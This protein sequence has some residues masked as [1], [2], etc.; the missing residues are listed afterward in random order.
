MVT[1]ELV[2][3]STEQNNNILQKDKERRF[4][5]NAGIPCAVAENE[6]KIYFTYDISDK[7]VKQSILLEE[8]FEL[9]KSKVPRDYIELLSIRPTEKDKQRTLLQ[10]HLVDYTA[11]NTFDY[12]IHKD[13][14]GFLSRELDFF[15]KNEVLY[16]DDINTRNEQEF[17]K[18]LSKIKAVKKIGDKIITFLSQIENF[19]KKLWLKKK[20]I[21]EC[22]YCITLDR[23]P[24]E[25]YQEI[26]KNKEQIN[27]W[28]RLFAIDEIKKDE[29]EG[30]FTDGF[31][32]YSNPPSI[33]SLK[34]N[35]YLV[36]DTVFFKEDF[37]WKL[38]TSIEN[39]D[40]KCDGLLINSENFQ[41]LNLL[42]NRFLEITDCI[43][44]DPPYNA[45]SS[46]ILYKNNFKHASWISLLENRISLSRKLLKDKF[47]HITAIDEVENFNIGKLFENIFFECENA[48]VS[49]VHN[50]TGQQGRNFSYTHEFAHFIYPT[51]GN[52]IGLENRD[53]KT[54]EAEPD[55]RPLRN[56]SSG[57]DHLRESAANCFYPIYIKD[58]KIIGFGEVCPV[59]FHPGKINIKRYDDTIEIYPV[60][61]SNI[62]S[63]WVFARNTVESII[64]E[65]T[66]EYDKKKNTWD[67]IRRKSKFRYKSLWCDKRY[68]ANSWGSVILNNI[69][70]KNPFTYPKSIYTVMDC[71]DAGL[72]NRN[73]GFIL[74]YF[75]GSGTTGHAII[76]LNR[77]DSG[78]RKY[79]LVEMGEYFDTVT[80]P[81]ILKVVYSK[82]WKDG[83]PISREGISHCI[84]YLRLES[85]EDTLNNLAL[86]QT[87]NQ[88]QALE[89]NHQFKEGYMLNYML[90]VETN[91]SLLNLEWFVNPFE[92]Y[93]NITKNNE[94]KPTK[95]DLVETFN[96]L[97]GLVVDNYSLPKD[98]YVIVTGKNLNDEK[99]LVVWRDCKKHNNIDLNRFLERSKYNPLDNEYNKIYV[100]GDNNVENLKIGDEQWK[101][102]L[103][104]EEFKKRMFEMN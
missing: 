89:I 99:I 47:V 88:Q 93:L 29:N 61:P 36:L 33:E 26:I 43:Y 69:L 101:V 27:E 46:E 14:Y 24:K 74:D 103:I 90:D 2:E 7:K 21:V 8:A 1:F 67:I 65:L 66:A 78:N 85:Y 97:I 98:G 104:E 84:K 4:A 15:I 32:E 68:S 100:N 19:Q 41:A 79:I 81:R 45:Q 59:D 87:D 52:Y 96:Y 55:I 63:K 80:K 71:I 54:R 60:D 9:V 10:K 40:N 58:G 5:L 57:K 48:C 3:A 16:I 35:P 37:K 34:Q 73:E 91:D 18:Q 56:V 70:P 38:I 76:N 28:V 39:F 12:F 42:L 92:C 31:V 13:L 25:L 72:N 102:V 17:L 44:I 77:S 51:N 23:V 86:K 95:V 82:D 83:K 64:E 75:A 94:I 53:D 20:M 30:M 50:P 62:E 11:R 6:F 22:N 49:I